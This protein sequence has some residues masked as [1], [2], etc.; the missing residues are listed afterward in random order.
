MD[1][2]PSRI[3]TALLFIASLCASAQD[4]VQQHADH[5]VP[6]A[7]DKQVNVGLGLGLDFGGLGGVRVDF[8]PKPHVAVFAGIGYALIGVGYNVGVIGRILPDKHA[9]PFVSVMYGYNAVI[10]VKGASQYD[11]IYYGPSFGAGVELH[12]RRS[13]NF[14]SLELLLPI[15]PVEYD[16]AITKLKT[17]PGVKIESE[18]P[19]FG[20]SGGYHWW[21]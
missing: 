4:Y 19:P 10:V 16:E 11:H 13:N 7:P 3:L 21:F 1:T 18:P 15:R 5:T 20:I 8:V 9:C 6:N 14:W 12:R 2:A 17:T